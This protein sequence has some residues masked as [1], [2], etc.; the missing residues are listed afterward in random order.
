M[1]K[2]LLISTLIFST[3]ASADYRIETV[4]TGLNFPWSIAFLPDGDYLVAMRSGE[5]RRI[6]SD[7]SVGEPLAGLPE[8]YVAG[9]GGYFDVVLDPD[10]PTNQ[11]I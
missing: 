4:A 6:G 1:R 5:V 7:G 3:L 11:R 9:Q 2:L 8:S 10:F